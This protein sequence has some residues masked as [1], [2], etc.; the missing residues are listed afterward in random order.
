MKNK[1]II[2]LFCLSFLSHSNAENLNIEASSITFDKKTKSTIFK[3][4]VIASDSKNNIFKTNFAEYDKE[5]N[6]L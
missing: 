6:C 1:I 2:F 3:G 4:E 5:Q